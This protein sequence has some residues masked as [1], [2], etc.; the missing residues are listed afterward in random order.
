M[1]WRHSECIMVSWNVFLFIKTFPQRYCCFLPGGRVRGGTG[2]AITLPT[3]AERKGRVS[4]VPL[5]KLQLLGAVN[6][7]RKDK[8][9]HHYTVHT[10]FITD[11][12][13]PHLKVRYLRNSCIKCWG[14][15]AGV[16][17][18]L[19]NWPSKQDFLT[20][21]SQKKKKQLCWVGEPT[22]TALTR[23]VIHM[24]M[25]INQL[26]Q[27]QTSLGQRWNSPFIYVGWK[28]Y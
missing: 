10:G 18:Q 23:L 20:K 26:Y 14:S 12:L 13:D 24:V 8:D 15:D 2:G 17:N 6:T 19:L 1:T 9:H 22:K 11:L 21:H 5:S 27:L 25:L 4:L 16:S 3:W 28:C 7:T